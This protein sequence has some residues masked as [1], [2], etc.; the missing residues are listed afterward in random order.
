MGCPRG[1]LHTNY[2]PAPRR[3]R[4]GLS[5]SVSADRRGSPARTD[6]RLVRPPLCVQVPDGGEVRAEAVRPARWADA[7]EECKAY[8]DA[9]GATRMRRAPSWCRRRT[10]RSAGPP[11]SRCPESVGTS[12]RAWASAVARGCTTKTCPRSSASTVARR[13][14]ARSAPRTRCLYGRLEPYVGGYPGLRQIHDKPAVLVADVQKSQPGPGHPSA[15]TCVAARPS[16]PGGR[17][18]R[19][20]LPRPGI[21]E[22][23]DVAVRVGHVDLDPSMA[24]SRQSRNHHYTLAHD[25]RRASCRS[26]PTVSPSPAPQV[27]RRNGGSA[28]TSTGGDRARPVFALPMRW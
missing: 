6:E 4:R 7:V 26:P 19:T 11:Q 15:V 23:R 27:T 12:P 21:P 8:G 16:P 5:A 18:R 25:R 1:D 22:L 3:S 28:P 17:S 20:G 14:S 24:T 2:T 13:R 10:A 9:T